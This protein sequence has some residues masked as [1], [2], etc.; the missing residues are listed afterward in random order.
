MGNKYM[1]KELRC[2]LG[3]YLLASLFIYP[4][5][6]FKAAFA[7]PVE[8]T[9]LQI[10]E[11]QTRNYNTQDTKMVMKAIIN[12]LQDDGYILDNFNIDLGI[13]TATKEVEVITKNAAIKKI[14]DIALTG[15]I[16]VAATSASHKGYTDN[17]KISATAN[18][19]NFNEHIKVRLNFAERRDTAENRIKSKSI[20]N[21]IFY[22]EFF[23]KLDKS[24]FIQKEK[25]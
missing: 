20:D 16:G 19:S 12:A 15:L 14:A 23:S 11:Y 9:P 7:E 24:L 5:T 13:I 21:E 2:L 3:L 1:K 8:K 4:I 17:L 18:I 22:Q 25:I 6:C 10:R